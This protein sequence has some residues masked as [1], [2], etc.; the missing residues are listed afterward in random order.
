MENQERKLTLLYFT[1][2]Q[3][4]STLYLIKFNLSILHCQYVCNRQL[5]KMFRT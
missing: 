5:T 3:I 4:L 2:V 1:H